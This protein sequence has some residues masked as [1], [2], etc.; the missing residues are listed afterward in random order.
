MYSFQWHNSSSIS[1]IEFGLEGSFSPIPMVLVMRVTPP[2]PT[3]PHSLITCRKP[4]NVDGGSFEDTILT[5]AKREGLLI[6]ATRL[7][8]VSNF[9]YEDFICFRP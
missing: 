5:L 1:C 3:P 9:L 2:H 8:D 7:S 6:S 4:V